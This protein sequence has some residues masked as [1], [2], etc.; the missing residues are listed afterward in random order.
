MY[1]FVLVLNPFILS[2]NKR[3]SILKQ[4]CKISPIKMYAMA[5]AKK[6]LNFRMHNDL[7]TSHVIFIFAVFKK[8]SQKRSYKMMHFVFETLKL[9]TLEFQL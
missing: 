9:L 3:S 4:I 7:K 2:V 1:Q 5:M 6:P 8:L